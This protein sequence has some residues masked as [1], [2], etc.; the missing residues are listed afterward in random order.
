MRT[1]KQAAEAS[2]IGDAAVVA[3]ALIETLVEHLDDRGAA[4]PG[5]A[6]AVLDRVRALA[7]AVRG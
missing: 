5:A 2:R 7:A 3:S 4:K 6:E 1:P